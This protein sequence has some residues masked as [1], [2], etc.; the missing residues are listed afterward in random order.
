MNCLYILEIKPLSVASFETISYHSVGCLFFLSFLIVSFAV[1][2]L[3][4]WIRSQLFIFVCI[5]IVNDLCF[6][7]YF[8]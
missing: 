4:C 5:S 8:V 7:G 2:K 1:Q 6:K 3:K